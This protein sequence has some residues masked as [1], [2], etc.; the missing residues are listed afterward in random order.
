MIL[1]IVFGFDAQDEIIGAVVGQ[2]Y[3]FLVDVLPK[4]PETYNLK[5]LDPPSFLV[6]FCN[7]LRIHEYNE[8]DPNLLGWFYTDDDDLTTE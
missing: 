8:L 2:I 3:Y 5:V 4:I 1:V 6:R 7:W